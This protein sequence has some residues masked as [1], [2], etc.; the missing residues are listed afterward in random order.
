MDA[1][2]CLVA[3]TP[4]T[5]R[6]R[7]MSAPRQYEQL[8]EHHPNRYSPTMEDTI[9]KARVEEPPRHL[10]SHHGKPV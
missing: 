1:C 3:P 5:P 4:L 2:P 6:R 7:Y 9:N 8:H 10:L